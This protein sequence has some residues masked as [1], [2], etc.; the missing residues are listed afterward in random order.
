MEIM[1]LRLLWVGKFESTK[2]I[3]L[4]Q[5]IGV[6]ADAEPNSIHLSGFSS[7]I[8]EGRSR[9]LIR[10][11]EYKRIKN[12]NMIMPSQLGKWKFDGLLL[13]ASISFSLV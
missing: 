5:A 3:F 1:C 12:S 8:L 13:S 10:I 7:G 6:A 11:P 2:S 4:F 9:S